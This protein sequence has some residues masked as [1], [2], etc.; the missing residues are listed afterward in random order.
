MCFFFK[1][2]MFQRLLLLLLFFLG[3]GG[4]GEGGGD[5]TDPV[6]MHLLARVKK[7]DPCEELNHRLHGLGR[8]GQLF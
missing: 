5:T 1:D 3:G 6:N 2:D 4:G 8:P 7:Y